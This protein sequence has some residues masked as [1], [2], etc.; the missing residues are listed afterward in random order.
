MADIFAAIDFTTVATAVG[1]SAVVVVGIAL[2]MQGI[3]IAKR[4][5]RKA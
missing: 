2:V 3:T 4:V 5:I 1:A